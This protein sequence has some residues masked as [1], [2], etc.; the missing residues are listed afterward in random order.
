MHVFA[1]LAAAE[2]RQRIC[3]D[4]LCA[5]TLLALI[6]GLFA[7]E[8]HAQMFSYGF[9]RPRAIQSVSF[10][11]Q[12]IDFSH[13]GDEAPE[14]S[15]EYDGPAFGLHYTRP[16]LT[17]GVAYG[18]DG[19]DRDM[20]ILTASILTWGELFLGGSGRRQSG[21]YVPIA[22]H[23]DYRRVAPRGSE[24]SV[25]DAFNVTVLGLGIGAGYASQFGK[26]VH[27]QA[28]AIPAIGLALRA[29]GDATGSSRLIDTD[30]RLHV[31]DLIGNAGV[32]LGYGFR[33]Q[34]WNVGS[35]D[36]LQE[37][38]NDLFDYGGSAHVFT[39]G[40]SW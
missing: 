34:V 33:T 10:A 39:I 12:I 22:I 5:F 4:G 21:F 25:V 29:F 38:E 23:T 40:V 16:N 32:S 35:S 19:S 18:A 14:P 2:R 6:P 31:V 8:A 26:T 36:L 28:R 11:Y 24:N 20:R 13:R 37:L 9:D 15:F 17:A 7:G 3:L 30:L 1:P 27:L